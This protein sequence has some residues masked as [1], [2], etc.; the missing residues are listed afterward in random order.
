VSGA[1]NARMDAQVYHRRS[2]VET[3]ISSLKRKYG[4]AVIR[5]R[6]S[7]KPL[8]KHIAV[9]EGRSFTELVRQALQ[10][11]LRR[12]QQKPKQAPPTTEWHQRLEQLLSRV[13]QRTRAYSAEE[14]ETDITDASKE[15]RRRRAPVAR[16]R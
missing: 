9:E 12:Y 5:W 14:I 11:F 1:A 3:V 4:S 8:L 10:E 7:T 16:P 15:V 2:L 6:I 13:R